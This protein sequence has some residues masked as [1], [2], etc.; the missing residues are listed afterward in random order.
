M[1]FTLLITGGLSAQAPRTALRFAQAAI[2]AGE[3][4][5][6]VFFYGDGVQVARHAGKPRP[7][8]LEITPAWSAFAA[9]QGVGLVACVAEAE[10]QGLDEAD[11]APGFH[12]GGLGQWIEAGLEC[13]RLLT[14]AA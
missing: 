5:G 7:G 4:V 1:K 14:F 10:R 11:L 13:D 6:L 8:D 12:I 2:D 9:A 3:G